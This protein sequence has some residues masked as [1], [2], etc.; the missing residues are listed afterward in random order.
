MTGREKVFYQDQLTTRECR[1]SEEID[2]E[3]TE[4]M[5]TRMMT[6]NELQ[7]RL[8]A[9]IL[10]AFGTDDHEIDEDVSL[11]NSSLNNTS[12]NRS[13]VSRITISTN[14]VSVQTETSLEKPQIRMN[15]KC[16]EA[17][18]STC[19]QVSTTCGLSVEMAR[20]AV[21][22][23]CNALYQHTYYLNSEDAMKDNNTDEEEQNEHENQ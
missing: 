3:H 14:E 9:E 17:I 6:E 19:A 15:R 8:E 11:H 18:K 1:L 12:L 7:E 10:Y 22:T 16:T 13:G 4:E 23:T 5:E 20:V 2:V 21:Q